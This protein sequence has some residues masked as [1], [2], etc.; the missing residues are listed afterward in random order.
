MSYN[1]LG[2]AQDHTKYLTSRLNE[3]KHYIYSVNNDPNYDTPDEALEKV[4]SYDRT[5]LPK[6]PTTGEIASETTTSNIITFN[7]Y[8]AS[9]YEIANIKDYMAVIVPNTSDIGYG[10]PTEDTIVDCKANVQ[11]IYDKAD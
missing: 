10:D 9:G 8:G 5:F 2:R 3:D 4:K 7:Y 11:D 6:L 1:Y